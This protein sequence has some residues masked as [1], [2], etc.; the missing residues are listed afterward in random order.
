M[1]SENV[2]TAPTAL[3][4]HSFMAFKSLLFDNC[5]EFK[6]QQKYEQY[7]GHQQMLHIY[8]D[9]GSSV[10]YCDQRLSVSVCL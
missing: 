9:L 2:H 1:T 3:S 7:Y 5:H 10:K 8:L 4:L 6:A